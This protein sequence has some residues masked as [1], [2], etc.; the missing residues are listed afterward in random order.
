MRKGR[1]LAVLISFLAMNDPSG[2]RIL[3]G[4]LPPP[5]ADEWIEMLTQDGEQV[6]VRS[7]KSPDGGILARI[8][9]KETIERVIRDHGGWGTI[10]RA[11]AL[12]RE[13]QPHEWEI[14]AAYCRLKTSPYR[15]QTVE[16]LAKGLHMGKSSLL[17]RREV[18]PSCI[19][20]LIKSGEVA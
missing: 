13:K 19:E 8:A 9:K 11:V 5:S 4:E 12:Y 6:H 7:D 18:V 3:Q 14:F 1:D 2:V 20:H 15:I 16:D 10:L 17:R